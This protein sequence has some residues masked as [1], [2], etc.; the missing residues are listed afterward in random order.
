M[1]I[2][3]RKTGDLE[4]SKSYNGLAVSKIKGQFEKTFPSIETVSCDEAILARFLRLAMSGGAGYLTLKACLKNS[5][6]N[7]AYRSIVCVSS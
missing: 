5:S 4:G 1:W 3:S 6:P 7:V 2:D